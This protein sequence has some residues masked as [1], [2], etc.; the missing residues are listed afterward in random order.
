MWCLGAWDFRFFF[1][2]LESAGF[3][4][5]GFEGCVGVQVVV[6]FIEPLRVI[7][8]PSGFNCAWGFFRV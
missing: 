1:G 4:H 8:M 6:C 5:V 2:G 7:P 3:E